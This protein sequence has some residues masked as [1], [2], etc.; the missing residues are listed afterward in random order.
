MDAIK[1]TQVLATG[2]GALA[3]TAH[4][5]ATGA[6]KVPVAALAASRARLAHDGTALTVKVGHAAVQG[7]IDASRG[8]EGLIGIANA[9]LIKAGGALID[10]AI[11]LRFTP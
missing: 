11:S 6:S 8:A 10:G 1:V 7:A 5:T 4:A 9:A 3:G 2:F